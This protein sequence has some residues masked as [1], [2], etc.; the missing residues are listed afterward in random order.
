MSGESYGG[1]YVPAI[2]HKVWLENKKLD[3]KFEEA[4]AAQK[5]LDSKKLRRAKPVSGFDWKKN[6]GF[7]SQFWAENHTPAI[8]MPKQDAVKINIKGFAV[9]N[10]LT[11]PLEQ[12][13]WYFSEKH[14]GTPKWCM[15]VVRL[16]E[17]PC[18]RA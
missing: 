12:Y 7:M 17:V 4:A 10:G 16:V 15:M 5:K 11:N 18:L 13:K 8:S 9:G 14:I 2:S 1:H 6:F 3:G